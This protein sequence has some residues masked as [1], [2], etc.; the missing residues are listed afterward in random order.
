M[1]SYRRGACCSFPIALLQVPVDESELT[2][3]ASLRPAWESFQTTLDTGDE[4]LKRSKAV[5]RKQLID[6]LSA[7]A[8]DL[9]DMRQLANDNLPYSGECCTP[10]RSAV[11][12]RSRRLHRQSSVIR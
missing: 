7:L 9:A 12:A 4:N 11:V 10:E 6:S 8:A 1:P 5:M 3:L 2:K